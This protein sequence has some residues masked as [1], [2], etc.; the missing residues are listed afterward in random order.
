MEAAI[1]LTGKPCRNGHLAHRYIK[2]RTCVECDRI[3]TAKYHA[4]HRDKV[5]GIYRNYY[6]ANRH[7]RCSE[8]AAY[9]VANPDKHRATKARTRAKSREKIQAYQAQWSKKN[10]ERCVAH[11]ARRRALLRVAPGRGFTPSEWQE[12]LTASLGLCAYC[13]D[14]VALTI[15]HIDP[16]NLGGSHDPDNIVPACKRCNS[17]KN[18]T[19][20]LLWLATRIR[21]ALVRSS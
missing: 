20:L 2:G 8:S 10:A 7:R 9:R 5:L 14:K 15:E 1:Y 4:T 3:K 18:D 11:T 6:A 12:A 21:L 19:P 17:S 13:T 16:L